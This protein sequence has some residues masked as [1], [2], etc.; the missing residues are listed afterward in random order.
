MK[1]ST[2]T[3]LL[4][5]VLISIVVSCKKDS[6]SNSS[7]NS[8]VSLITNGT[9]KFQKFEYQRKDGI[10]IADPDAVDADK[11]TIAFNSNNTFSELDLVNNNSAAGG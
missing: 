7:A 2:P 10:W 4:F 9:W 5:I 3:N 1:L 6:G 11:F 8:S